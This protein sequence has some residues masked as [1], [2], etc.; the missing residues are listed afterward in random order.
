MHAWGHT[1]YIWLRGIIVT[2]FIHM[3][4]VTCYIIAILFIHIWLRAI[5][6]HTIYT[7]MV[8]SYIYSYTIYTCILTFSQCNEGGRG[9]LKYST[10]SDFLEFW[11]DTNSNK[12]S[13]LYSSSIY[14]STLLYSS[15][16][17]LRLCMYTWHFISLH[18]TVSL[19]LCLMKHVHNTS[20]KKHI[21]YIME[22][23]V[24]KAVNLSSSIMSTIKS[25]T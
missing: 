22:F 15:T 4:M 20:H 6:S 10:Y 1:C 11:E 5:Y 25:Q 14:S 19:Q 8:T 23:L 2:L 3:Y 16:Y 13:T 17:S 9:R 7:Y 24:L 21:S 18:R 12:H